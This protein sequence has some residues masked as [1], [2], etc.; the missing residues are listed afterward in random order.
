[1]AIHNFVFLTGSTGL[2]GGHLLIHL[3]HSGRRVRAL[4]RPSSSF[5]QLHLICVFYRQSFE[6]LFEAVDW[7]YGDTLDYISL[8]DLLNGAEEVFHCA[9]IVSF[10]SRNSR[11]LFQ[12]NI[13]GTSNMVDAAIKCSV[14][15]FCFIS[16]IS[17]L[18]N[19][20]GP[21]F[22]NE[23]T[24]RMN[25]EIYSVYSDSKFRSEL[26]VWRANSEGLE[27]V[28]LNPG[29]VLGPGISSKGSLL[30]FQTVQ[31]GMPFYTNATTGY[32]DVR[33]ICR[34]GIELMEKGL[35]GKRFILVSEN[36]GDKELLSMIALE[37][38]VKP[39]RYHVGK[40]LLQLSACLSEFI[41]KLMGLEPKLTKDLVKAV[42]CPH[43]YSSQQIKTALNFQFTP[44][45][46]TIQDTC[47]FI[48][49]NGL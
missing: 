39:P 13:Q 21:N 44:L 25:E 18:G 46:K 5:E 37:F 15:R 48:K 7:V 20:N 40:K 34:A 35:F 1:M 26:E 38:K 41:S 23:E 14:K 31:K 16:S 24:P 30:L 11:Q 9:G 49:E 6:E 22:I 12:T 43:K 28:I 10:D 8:C 27:T 29:V 17:A 45:R 33:D 42:Q 19:T 32:I 4:I 3:H 36:I 2:V 47:L